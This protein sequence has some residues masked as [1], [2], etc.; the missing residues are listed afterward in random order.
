MWM[1]WKESLAYV[2]ELI[3]GKLVNLEAQFT[4]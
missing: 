1:I 3:N 2:A 4:E